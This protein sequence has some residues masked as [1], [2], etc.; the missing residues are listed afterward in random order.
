MCPSVCHS[1]RQ[2]SATHACNIHHRQW[3]HTH[4]HTHTQQIVATYF[5]CTSEWAWGSSSRPQRS[6][7]CAGRFF[8]FLAKITSSLMLNEIFAW[9]IIKKFLCQQITWLAR[10]NKVRHLP[11]PPTSEPSC[12]AP[13]PSSDPT[14]LTHTIYISLTNICAMC[15]G[16]LKTS[17]TNLL[18]R[19]LL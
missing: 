8:Q 12:L 17:Q 6:E 3:Q 4:T 19:G 7:A 16:N 14:L 5:T 10:L 13:A 15:L 2:I 18:P 11:C 9:W 1:V